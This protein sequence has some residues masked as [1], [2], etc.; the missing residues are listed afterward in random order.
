MDNQSAKRRKLDADGTFQTHPAGSDVE[1][2]EDTATSKTDLDAAPDPQDRSKADELGLQQG[3]GEDR[4]MLLDSKTEVS[5]D[6]SCHHHDVDEELLGRFAHEHEQF[7][8]ETS[9]PH[10]AKDESFRLSGFHPALS[11]AQ[12]ELLKIVKDALA[13]F[14]EAK[15]KDA[16]TTKLENDLIDLQKIPQVGTTTI[17]LIG[18]SG[19]GT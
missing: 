16:S 9:T 8:E 14:K 7:E 6:A 10:D 11:E 17:G 4:K 19:V 5:T 12:G 2:V 3:D 1:L 13:V 15:Y 18:N